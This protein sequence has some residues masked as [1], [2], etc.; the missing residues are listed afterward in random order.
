M[1]N[2]QFETIYKS[3]FDY[4][5]RY[6]LRL[7]K[8]KDIAEELTGETFFKALKAI[9]NFRGESDIGT[10]LCQIA[11]NSY[12]RYIKNL[13]DSREITEADEAALM[14]DSGINI[15]RQLV[16]GETSMDIY[17][18]MAGIEEPYKSVFCFR[19]LGELSFRQIGE[20]YGKTE[21]WACVTYHRGKEKIK[22]ILE[23]KL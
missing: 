15:E 9:D 1:T 14:A 7:C 11:R 19:V 12:F 10:W 23:G 2:S 22:K 6:L 5:Y 4:V 20:I 16:D 18:A 13:K 3:Y 21:N 8:D 17:K